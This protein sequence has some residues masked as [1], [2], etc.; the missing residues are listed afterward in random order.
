MRT[1]SLFLTFMLLVG[2][3]CAF[4]YVITAAFMLCHYVLAGSGVLFLTAIAT[5]IFIN[6]EK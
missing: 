2:I 5:A 3:L 6:W 4:G 1:L